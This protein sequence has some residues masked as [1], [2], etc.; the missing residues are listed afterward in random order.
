[1]KGDERIDGGGAV[2]A[3]G[4]GNVYVFWHATK[5][6]FVEAAGRVY[7]SVSH[8]GGKT[9]QIPST[10]DR[11]SDGACAC[12][13]MAAIVH[14]GKLFVLYRAAA[15]GTRRDT[16]LL[17]SAD[18]GESCKSTILQPWEINQCPVSRF[19]LCSASNGVFA[20][21]ETKGRIFYE[22]VDDPAKISTAPQGV[23][24]SSVE[25]FP[26]ISRDADNILVTW[27]TVPAWGQ[28]GTLHWEVHDPSGKL[29]SASA[30]DITVPQW[31]YATALVLGPAKFA[32]IH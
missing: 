1:I 13:N 30:P 6:D 18:G 4:R 12:C 14:D 2:A 27:T 24:A 16:I 19:S 25:K 7:L 15:Q 29:L 22:R 8:D 21:W 20:A 31:S 9:F 26:T 11:G 10:V 23:T 32:V 17:T 5:A 3:D 28:P